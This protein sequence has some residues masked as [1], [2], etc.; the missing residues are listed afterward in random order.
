MDKFLNNDDAKVLLNFKEKIKKEIKY[1]NWFKKIKMR[2]KKRV[3][4]FAMSFL[5][6]IV[7]KYFKKLFNFFKI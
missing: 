7:P 4:K 3:K 2:F 1:I 6:I 5:I